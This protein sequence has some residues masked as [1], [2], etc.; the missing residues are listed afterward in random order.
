MNRRNP[1]PTLA[2]GHARPLGIAIVAVLMILFGLSEVVTGFTHNFFGLA[3]A[4][5]TFSNVAVAAVGTFYVVGGV[6]ILTMRK[7]AAALAILLLLADIVGR[8]M[9]VVTGFYPLTS[10][11]QTAGIIVGTLIAALFAIYVGSRWASFR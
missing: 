2:N 10:F 5:R 4:H 6:L 9:L 8:V 7:W 3:T 1:V 11:V